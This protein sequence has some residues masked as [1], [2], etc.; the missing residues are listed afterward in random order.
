MNWE[1][2]WGLLDGTT[3]S[4]YSPVESV[5]PKF[6]PD[7]K[8][9]ED[10]DKKR[11]AQLNRD[12]ETWQREQ[13]FG[14]TTRELVDLDAITTRKLKKGDLRNQLHP[15]LKRKNWEVAPDI[16]HKRNYMYD[17]DPTYT[18]ECESVLAFQAILISGDFML[19]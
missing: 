5:F 19:N 2:K 6:S 8:D 10:I 3:V 18:G 16:S 11:T 12:R 1:P 15:L 13:L 17:L 7:P 4:G 14:F 9:L